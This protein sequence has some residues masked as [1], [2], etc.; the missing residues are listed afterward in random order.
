MKYFILIALMGLGSTAALAASAQ[1]GSITDE[2]GGRHERHDIRFD[3]HFRSRIKAGVACEARG[4][5]CIDR[6]NH[7]GMLGEDGRC[8]SSGGGRSRL[9]RSLSISCND[10]YHDEDRAFGW[11]TRNEGDRFRDR[12]ELVIQAERFGREEGALA[13]SRIRIYDVRLRNDHDNHRGVVNASVTDEDR[14]DR[15]DDRWTDEF[16]A[17]FHRDGFIGGPFWG[18]CLLNVERHREDRREEPKP[19]PTK[20]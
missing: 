9:R 8:D 2:N 1:T 7:M 5:V 12:D 15:D 19:E 4:E 11:L 14:R 3:C 17:S 18:R 6:H 20:P 16:D 13:E 10:G